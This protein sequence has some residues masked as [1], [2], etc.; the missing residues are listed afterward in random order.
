[1]L[2]EAWMDCGGVVDRSAYTPGNRLACAFRGVQREPLTT[3]E[4]DSGGELGHQKFTLFAR[5]RCSLWIVCG[6]SFRHIFLKIR[7]SCPVLLARL[8]IE[9]RAGVCF[10]GE[11]RV[12]FC[13]ARLRRGSTAR[14]GIHR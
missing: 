9:N 8:R 7:Q 2:G 4:S 1:M 6:F 3:A 13:E 12:D 11:A 14:T 5:A 10:D